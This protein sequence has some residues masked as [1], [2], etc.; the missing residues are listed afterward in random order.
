MANNVTVKT[1]NEVAEY[2]R[3][4]IVGECRFYM[5]QSA[6]AMLEAGKRLL[7]IRQ[8][9]EHGDFLNIVEN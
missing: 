9:E 5:S 7:E 3:N 6:E 1:A 2:D 4:R 8:N